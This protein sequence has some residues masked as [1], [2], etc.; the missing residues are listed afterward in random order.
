[1]FGKFFTYLWDENSDDALEKD[2]KMLV[3]TYIPA[4]TLK[5]KHKAQ[6]TTWYTLHEVHNIE[7]NRELYNRDVD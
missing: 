6:N 7:V 4:N 2:G 1:M 3:D 5:I